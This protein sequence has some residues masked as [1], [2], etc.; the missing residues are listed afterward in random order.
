[1]GTANGQGCPYVWQVAGHHTGS[2]A[3]R[4]SWYN[5]RPALYALA[6]Q[7]MLG[8]EH[9]ATVGTV[10]TKP[11]WGMLFGRSYIGG[12]IGWSTLVHGAA[13]VSL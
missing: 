11:V 10:R 2:G 13:W 12:G 3:V 8:S 5:Q 4:P 6:Q 1:M 9:A 7:G